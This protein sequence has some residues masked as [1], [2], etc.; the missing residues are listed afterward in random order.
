MTPYSFTRA[1]GTHE[2]RISQSQ[3]SKPEIL[4]QVHL[5][6]C[7][8]QKCQFFASETYFVM[9]FGAYPNAGSLQEYEATPHYEKVG[10]YPQLTLTHFSS[11]QFSCLVVSNSL[12]HHGLQHARLLCPSPTPRAFSHSCP[13]SRWCHPTISSS[14]SFIYVK[15]LS[16][17]PQ[18]TIL[19]KN[20]GSEGWEL[21]ARTL[22]F[23]Q[24]TLLHTGL[25]KTQLFSPPDWP[26]EM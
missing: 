21:V 23:Y 6:R 24:I 15:F 25:N 4:P 10:K 16:P 14:D 11:V 13:A 20:D 1:L 26:L 19:Q 12:Q 17:L 3:F 2:E 8:P 7:L 22:V 5:S 9:S 18:G